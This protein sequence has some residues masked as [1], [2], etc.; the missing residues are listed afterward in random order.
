M[1]YV[2]FSVVLCSFN[3]CMFVVYYYYFI[4]IFSS[5]IYIY[6]CSMIVLIQPLGCHTLINDSRIWSRSV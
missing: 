5:F 1:D 4:I 3:V 6:V 2:T